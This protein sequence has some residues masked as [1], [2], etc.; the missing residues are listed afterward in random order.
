MAARSM[1]DRVRWAVDL[2]APPADARVLE[3]GCGPGAAAELLCG[4]LT[5]GTLL[6]IDRSPIAVART[7][8]RNAGHIGDGRLRVIHGV[9]ADLAVDSGAFDAALAVDVNVFW[10]TSARAELEV[11]A[12]ALAPGGR[13][14]ILYGPGPGTEAGGGG[15]GDGDRL[16]T[17]AAAVERC[18]FVHP[19]V[20]RGP[21]GSGVIAVRAGGPL[22]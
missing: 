5:R 22:S 14:A 1:P 18:G 13:L 2:L 12:H 11:I 8:K 3:V 4:R 16:D 19:S 10:T 9:L 15:D 21:R 7:E 20:V 17:I 6:A